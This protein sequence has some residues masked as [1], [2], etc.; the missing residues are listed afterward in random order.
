MK[1]LVALPL[2]VALTAWA[3]DPPIPLPTGRYEFKH[4]FAEHPDMTSITLIAEII[5]DQIELFN[6]DS[7][8]LFNFGVVEKGTLMWHAATKTWIIGHSHE[9]RVAP[10]VGACTDGPSEVDLV[11]LVYWTC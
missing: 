3:E 2:F 4:R 5:D 11:E 8:W 1:V 9:D 10:H 7:D 6:A